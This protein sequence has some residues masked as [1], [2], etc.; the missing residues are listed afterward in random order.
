MLVSSPKTEHHEG[1]ASRW[2]PLFP[3]LRPYLVEA[4]ERAESR[5]EFVISQNRNKTN[6]RTPFMKIIKRAG[7]TPWP[8]LF[9]NLRST[10]QTELEESFPS[11]VV[12]AWMGNSQPVARKHYLQVTEDHFAEAVKAGAEPGAGAVQNQVQHTTADDGDESQSE[13]KTPAIAGVTPNLAKSRDRLGSVLMD[14]TGLEP[15]TSTMSTWRSNQ[16]ELIVRWWKKIVLAYWEIYVFRGRMSNPNGAE[17]LTFI[18]RASA[19]DYR[20][21]WDCKTRVA[22]KYGL[23]SYDSA[24]LQFLAQMLWLRPD[25]RR[26]ILRSNQDLALSY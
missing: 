19:R 1:K 25:Q 22:D 18:R 16:T 6:W 17:S 10:R 21:I 23:N 9:Q 4:F 14:D 3:E 12:C 24:K 13:K 15:V 20:G 11:H 5:A 7:L 2:L 26:K 8:K